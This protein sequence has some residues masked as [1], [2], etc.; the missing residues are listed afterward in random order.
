MPEWDR[1]L[2]V[3]GAGAV[4]WVQARGGLARWALLAVAVASVAGFLL[5]Q[6][7]SADVTYGDAPPGAT[8]A[9]G[10]AGELSD[11]TVPSVEEMQRMV[12]QSSVV[13]LP[14]AVA[15][16]DEAAVRAAIGGR[17]VRILVAPPGL[18]KDAQARVRDVDN[19][20]VRVIG[21]RVSGG[22]Y[23][24]SGTLLSDW[25]AQFARNDI[26]GQLVA[27]ITEHA[28][29]AGATP[30]RAPSAAELDPVLAALRTGEQYGISPSGTALRDAFGTGGALVVALPAQPRDT[31]APDYG[32]ALEQAF[33]DRPIV[34]MVGTWIEYHGPHAAEFAD[35]AAAGFFARFDER[36]S[37]YAYPQANVLGAYLGWVTDVRYSGLFD[38][39]LP[40]QPFDPLRV[41]LPVLPWLFA[42]CVI[43][44]LLLSGRS[45]A[46]ARR[47]PVPAAV[48][49]RLAALSA[50]AVEVSGLTTAAGDPDLVRAITRLASARTALAD[51]LPDR[52]LRRL[53]DEAEADLDRVGRTVGVRGYR[54]AEHAGRS[55]A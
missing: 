29:P 36:L 1:R 21:T 30:W 16:W 32:P 20:T 3:P 10:S 23:A 11:A 40:Y 4:Q 33:P 6:R 41:A 46:P 31:P 35:V 42:A 9:E 2:R 38:R 37:T 26:T 17:D 24:A 55:P 15:Q 45:V 22:I 44:F 39:P 12:A 14:G 43:G 51:G 53:L 48:P 54:P 49:A 50:L 8:I 52:H 13:R 18:G 47:A 7:Q 34:L 19:A 25:K 28:A 27:L 5:A